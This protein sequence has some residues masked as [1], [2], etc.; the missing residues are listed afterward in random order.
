MRKIDT[1][2]YMAE[3]PHRAELGA[4]GSEQGQDEQRA[5]RHEQHLRHTPTARCFGAAVYRAA[6]GQHAQGHHG[7]ISGQAEK[8]EERL[9]ATRR[10]R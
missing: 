10:Q 1:G 8:R 9:G 3:A 2:H 6:E 5:T 7:K 4:D